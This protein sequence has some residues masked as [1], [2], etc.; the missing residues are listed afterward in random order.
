MNPKY[1]IKNFRVFDRE[2][3]TFELAPLTIFTGCNSSGK[4]SMAKSLLV[5]GNYITKLRN[6]IKSTGDFQPESIDG[7]Q[8][9]YDGITFEKVKS[10]SD[11]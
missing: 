8:A 6:E 11:E 3:A 7:T 5:L 9:L 4:S 2:G 1:T 10:L